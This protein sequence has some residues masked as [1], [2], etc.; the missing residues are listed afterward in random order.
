MTT[1]STSPALHPK[2]SVTLDAAADLVR[3]DAET[4]RRWWESG[5]IEVERRGDME[6]VRLDQVRAAAAAD[7]GRRRPSGAALRERLD[8]ASLGD[9][10]SVI[11]LQELARERGTD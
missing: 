6:V 1:T 7:R 2:A 9:T 11:D 8:G 3:V 4:I 10:L 5:S